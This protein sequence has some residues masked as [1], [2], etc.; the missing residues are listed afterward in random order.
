ML[1]LEYQGQ[2]LVDHVMLNNN[3]TIT[4]NNKITI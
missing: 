1:V 4:S 3:I 2:F